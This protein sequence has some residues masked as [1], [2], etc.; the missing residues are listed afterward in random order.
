MSGLSTNNHAYVREF[1]RL[2][3]V[4]SGDKAALGPYCGAQFRWRH[5][6]ASAK[7]AV[8][9]GQVPEPDVERY[10]ADLLVGMERIRQQLVRADKALREH[11]LSEGRAL[12]FEQPLDPPRLDPMARSDGRYGEV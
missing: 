2:V 4:T 5:A 1:G 7:R 9:I 3:S 10:G 6:I 11:I 12:A 8:K